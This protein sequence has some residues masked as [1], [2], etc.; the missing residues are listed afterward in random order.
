M[1]SPGQNMLQTIYKRHSET[2]HEIQDFEML[3]LNGQFGPTASFWASFL[4]M[5]QTLFNFMRSIK[6]GN[7]KLHLQSTEEILAW[8]FAYDRPNYA[9]FLTYYMASM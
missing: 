4:Q 6:L 7:W 2:I 8:M 3:L 1:R 9:R 5:F